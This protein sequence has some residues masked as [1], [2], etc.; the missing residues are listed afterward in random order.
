MWPVGEG[1]KERA[2]GLRNN[3]EQADW[4][5]DTRNCGC[6]GLSLGRVVNTYGRLSAP[7][8]VEHSQVRS[9]ETLGIAVQLPGLGCASRNA[10]SQFG[11]Y[12]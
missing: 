11:C 6:Q 5:D 9:H 4:G 8:E 2:E 1:F 3:Q 12:I 10:L 7:G